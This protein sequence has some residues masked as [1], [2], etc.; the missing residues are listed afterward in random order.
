MVV[1]DKEKLQ[2][3]MQAIKDDKKELALK[4]LR[5]F[6]QKTYMIKQRAYSRK[7]DFLQVIWT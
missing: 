6:Q 4:L 1:T 3:A 5:A 7:R 2:R